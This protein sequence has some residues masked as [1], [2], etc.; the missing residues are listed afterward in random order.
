MRTKGY[1]SH[2][3]RVLPPESSD[4]LPFINKGKASSLEDLFHLRR[5]AAIHGPSCLN[6]NRIPLFRVRRQKVLLRPNRNQ[7]SA[8]CSFTAAISVNSVTAPQGPNYYGIPCASWIILP[9]ALKRCIGT[10]YNLFSSAV[11]VASASEFRGEVSDVF[12][13]GSTVSQNGFR[14]LF[15]NFATCVFFLFFATSGRY[16]AG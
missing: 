1:L 2:L 15:S 7:G 5:K 11:L 16:H 8:R 4:P 6:R 9:S 12:H 10:L 14:G 13:I 3:L